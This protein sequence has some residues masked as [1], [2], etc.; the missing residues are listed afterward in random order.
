MGLKSSL[1][2]VVELD[3]VGG[4]DGRQKAAHAFLGSEVGWHGDG[5]VLV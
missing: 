3:V 2:L 5:C 1:T 4:N